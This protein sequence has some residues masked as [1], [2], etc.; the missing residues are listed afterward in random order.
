MNLIK[1]QKQIRF[2][3][4]FFIIGLLASGIT[5]FPL[6]LEIGILKQFVDNT[7]IANSIPG[8]SDWI[9]KVYQGITTTYQSFP[10]MAYGTD[11][12][13]FAH[14]VIAIAFIGPLRDPIKNIWVIEFGM[15]A[16]VLIIPLALIFG[17]LR[18]IPF[19]WSLIDCSFGV[20][21]IIPLWLARRNVQSL[22]RLQPNPT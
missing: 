5:A 15:I 16:C 4:I 10:F 12:L 1:L 13:G 17:P 9:A 21:G 11:W 22:A 3:I 20:I 2:L 19:G 8:L 18:G 7:Q 6:Q 14:I